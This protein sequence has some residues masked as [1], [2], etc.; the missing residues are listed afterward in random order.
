M[1]FKEWLNEDEIVGA[2]LAN[3]YRNA[4][5]IMPKSKQKHSIRVTK[6]VHNLF[7]NNEL[8]TDQWTAV[9]AAIFHDFLERGGDHSVLQKLGLSSQTIQVINALTADKNDGDPLE[10][11]QTVL[12]RLDENL[13]NIVILIKISDRIDNLSR[14]SPNVGRNYMER[15]STLVNW[16]FQQYT[17]EPEY[18]FILR[19]RLK[20]LGVKA[21]K[22]YI[23]QPQQHWRDD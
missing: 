12:P 21:R 15:S 11:L 9:T 5:N 23:Y 10:H 13:R 1:N 20:Q 6:Q 7:G 22:K 16:L 3:Q 8:D 17:G 4:L 14:R 2:A 18:L 19:K